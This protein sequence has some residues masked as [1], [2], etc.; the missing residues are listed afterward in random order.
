MRVL[1]LGYSWT[2]FNAAVHST[3]R[4]FMPSKLGC[5]IDIVDSLF[6]CYMFDGYFDDNEGNNN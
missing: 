1:R 4:A 5:V 3:G 6:Y 2:D